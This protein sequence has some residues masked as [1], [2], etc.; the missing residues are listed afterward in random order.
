[1]GLANPNYQKKRKL[2][3]PFMNNFRLS[4]PSHTIKKTKP[5]RVVPTKPIRVV[6]TKPTRSESPC[7]QNNVL[8]SVCQL[9]SSPLNTTSPCNLSPQ[10]SSMG[11]SAPVNY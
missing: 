5:N 1:M 4:K 10:L 11:F 3:T 9:L 2:E 7:L 6:P 8:P